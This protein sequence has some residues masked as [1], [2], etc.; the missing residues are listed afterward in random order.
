MPFCDSQAIRRV[1]SRV[2]HR[3]LSMICFEVAV[4]V[5]R[6]VTVTSGEAGAKRSGGSS[7]C[8][9]L[10]RWVFAKLA[11]FGVAETG[12]NPSRPVEI[13]VASRRMRGYETSRP[14][15]LR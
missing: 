6:F 4:A 8:G 2:Q 14:L 5:Y 13:R 15:A 11:V 7:S 1:V 10:T 12:P 9:R 3:C